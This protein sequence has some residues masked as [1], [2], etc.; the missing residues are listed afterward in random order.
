MNARAQ[1]NFSLSEAVLSKLAEVYL[2]SQVKKSQ[3]LKIDIDSNP[4]KI[5]KGKID[6]ISLTGKKLVILGNLTIEE[7]ILDSNDITLNLIE[8]ISGKI[9]LETPSQFTAKAILT[10][11]D[12]DRL[13][14]SKYLNKL[15]KRLPV[16]IKERLYTFQIQHAK[17]YLKERDKLTLAAEL[18]LTEGQPEASAS[19][20]GR[21]DL[22]SSSKTKTTE[23]EI[24]LS[25]AEGGAKI[26]LETGKYQ[27]NKA[28]PLEATI[29][30][31][32][33]IKELLYFR[34][35]NSSNFSFEIYKLRIEAKQL[36]ISV[37]GNVKRLPSSIEKPL[38]S[39]AIKIN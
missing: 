39:A 31:I 2:S 27:K 26:M 14:N 5:V 23:F 29:E 1:N 37:K 16:K 8:I 24:D 33:K 4:E 15:L 28:L 36:I 11:P 12:C 6:S 35:F 17:C 13:L 30:I 7:I 19:Q 21:E 25:L 38:N 9:E 3:S 22:A 18:I 32:G 34:C 10:T 20:A